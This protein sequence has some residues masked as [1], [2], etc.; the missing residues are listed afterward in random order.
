MQLKGFTLIE[1]MIT[2]ALAGLV[3]SLGMLVYRSMAS[4]HSQYQNQVALTYAGSGIQYMLEN[5]ASKAFSYTWYDPQNICLLGRDEEQIYCYAL[6]DS[7]MVRSEGGR[8][9]TLGFKGTFISNKGQLM[10]RDEELGLV[11]GMH[12]GISKY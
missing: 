6:L 5:D 4:M 2:L 7:T 12:C 11:Y 3:V 1:T 10:L 8:H 9:D